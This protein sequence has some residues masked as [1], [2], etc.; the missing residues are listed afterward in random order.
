MH[1]RNRMSCFIIGEG[2]LPIQCAEIL[3]DR[4]HDIYGIVSPDMSLGQWAREK[5]L[6]YL[7]PV[8]NGRLQPVNLHAFLAQ[9]P[10]DYLFSIVNYTFLPEDVLA[11][12]CQKAINYHD[13][14][15]PRYAGICATSWA[16]MQH[17]I[18]HGITWHVATRKIDAGDIIKQCLVD[19]GPDDTAFTLNM[20]CYQAAIEAFAEMVDDLAGGQASFRPQN[21]SERTYYSVYKRP[22]R[23]CV[24]SWDQDTRSIE[25]FVRALEFGP[26]PNR[27]GL[28][29]LA[30]GKDFFIISKLDVLD[31]P[32]PAPPGT[33]V[34]VDRDFLT[35]STQTKQVV[36]RQLTTIEGKPLSIPD[37]ALRL[38]LGKGDRLQDL[39]EALADR[40]TT[41][42]ALICKHEPFWVDRLAA[43]RPLTLPYV[44]APADAELVGASWQRV[45]LP[46]SVLSEVEGFLA[47]HHLDW[48]V[49][50]FMRIAFVAYLA[51]LSGVS[52]FDIGCRAILSQGDG[53]LDLAGLE[54]F[55]AQHV[56]LHV[57][58][59]LDWGFEQIYQAVQV[60]LELI[61]R[62]YTY[63]RDMVARYPRIGKEVG[64]PQWP[65]AIEHV[66]NLDERQPIPGGQ[67]ALLISESDGHP[68][69]CFAY[70]SNCVNEATAASM[71]HQFTLLLHA[72][73]TEGADRP[74]WSL[75]LLTPAERSQIVVEWNDTGI[76]Y[77]YAPQ[78]G[79]HQLFEIQAERTPDAVALVF[80][81]QSLTY[82]ELNRR[83][84]K[85]A[86]YLQGLGVGPETVVG[87]CME[88]CM[89]MVIGLYGTLK[90]GAA[91]MPLDP[92]YPTQRLAFMVEDAQSPLVLTREK[93]VTALPAY[94]RVGPGCPPGARQNPGIVCL[95]ADWEAIAAE[96]ADRLVSKVL[97]DYPAYVIYTS[98]ST[99][100][101]K[102]VIN[103]QAGIRNRLL[104][105]QSAYQLDGSDRV[106][107]KT[108]F[109]FDVSVWEFFWP[110]LTGACLVV[111]QPEG[112]RDNAY[113]IDLIV[114]QNVTTMHFVPSMLRVFI[115]E[116]GIEACR[117]L[118]RVL[119]SGEALPGDLQERFF[120]RL[121]AELHNLYG[122]TE[123]AVDVTYWACHAEGRQRVVPIG[124][125]I[126][127]T[128]IYILDAHGCPVPVG[129]PG[130][131][132]IG[133]AGLARGYLNRP[134]LTAEKFVPDPFSRNPGARLY[135][136]GDLAR[137]LPDGTIEF[138]ERIDYQVKVRGFRIELGEIESTLA[139]HP[140]V[141]KV[142]V[143]A[144][145]DM[146]DHKRLTAYI[147][148]KRDFTP[149]SGALRDFL[150]ERLP[151]YM[152]PSAFVL[153]KALPLTAHGK[154]DRRALPLP[155]Q[156]QPV[157]ESLSPP[158]TSA[159]KTLAKI[160]SQVFGVEVGIHDDFFDE[161][162][163]DS[164][165]GMQI[166]AKANQAGFQ[167]R[168]TTLLKCRTIAA[169][170]AE[171]SVSRSAQ[172]EQNAVVGPVPLTPV[173]RWFFE[174]AIPQPQH[175]NQAF[176]FTLR[177]R[178]SLPCLKM[179]V[180]HVLIHHDALRLRFRREVDG[181]Q[182]I[183]EGP[184]KVE[185]SA[186]VCVVDLS[187]LGAEDQKLA[188]ESAT[189]ELHASLDL[190]EGPL[191]RIALF[192]FGAPRPDQM[193]IVIHHL[194]VDIVSWQILLEDLQ[195]AYHQLCQGKAVELPRKTTSF[196]QW[197][198]R[199]AAYVQSEALQPDVSYWLAQPRDR[200]SQLPRDF[201]GGDN[202]EGSGHGVSAS[203]S[204][205][206]TQALL[207][208]V[209]VACNAR[210]D[211]VLLATLA[212]VLSQWIGSRRMVIDLEGHGREE[213]S[214]DVDLLRTVG[215][216][217]AIF[218]VWLDMGP[219]SSLTDTLQVVQA[220]LRDI[221]KRGMGYGLLRYLS[222]DKAV[223]EQ[224]QDRSPAEVSFNYMGRFDQ[225]FPPSTLLELSQVLFGPL[226]SPSG[227]RRYIF[228]INAGI[229]G[230]QFQL[231]WIYSEN[232][233]RRATVEEL[234]HDFMANLRSLTAQSQSVEVASAV[235]LDRAEQWKDGQPFT[236][237][238]SLENRHSPFPLSDMQQAYWIGRGSTHELGNV[239]PHTYFEFE[240]VGL[241]LDRLNHAL[242][243]VINR[244]EMLRTAVLPDGQQ[245]I[246][247][248]V[249][250]EIEVVDLRGLDVQVAAERLE[251]A[252]ESMSHM[253]K[254][255]DQCPLFE[256]R[257]YLLEN[258]RVRLN[259]SWDS[260]MADAFSLFLFMED[261]SQFYKNPDVLLPPLE[262]SFRDY[263]LA[264][265]ASRKSEAYQRSLSYWQSR[266]STLPP[267]PE[268]PLA[269]SPSGIKYPRF[270]RRL[271]RLEAKRW[272]RIKNRAKQAGLTPA[273]VLCAAHSEI[274]AAWSKS[275]RFTNNV[276][277][278]DRR[279]FHPQ[280]ND[281]VGDFTSGI[282]L[283]TDYS[284]GDTFEAR[285]QGLQNQLWADLEHTRVSSIRVLRELGR[286]Q[287]GA[288][289]AM[290]I[291]FTCVLNLGKRQGGLSLTSW[292]GD[293]VYSS[294]Q[295]PQVW[296]DH[297]IFEDGE[298]LFFTWD[299]VEELFP[300]GL[301]DDMFGAYC[302]LLRRLA[303][304]DKLWRQKRLALVPPD[305]LKRQRDINASGAPI[306]SELLHTLFTAQV[307]KRRPQPAVVDVNRTLTYDE[308]DRRSNQVARRLRAL[309][310]RPNQ[311]VAVVMEKGW[312]Q[313]VAVLGVH[314]A[315]AAYLPVNAEQPQE[316]LHYLLKNGQV[317]V[318]LTQS[319]LD[320]QLE[321]PNAIHRLCVDVQQDWEGLDDSPLEPVQNAKDLAYVIYT[322]GS[323]G[324]PKGVMID[325]QGA[326]NTILDINRRCRIGP[327]DRI[328]ALS[329][330]SFDLSVYD[331]FGALAAGATIVMPHS[332]GWR[333]PAH[334]MPLLLDQG[335]TVWDSV[336]ALMEML[337]DYAET[338]KRPLPST[339]RL[340][341]MSGDWIPVN[342][343]DRIRK[344]RKDV[345]VIS[346]GGA[347]EASIWSILY[348]IGEVD[349]TWKS[350]PYG[351]PMDNQ[352]FYVL[353]ERMEERPVWTPGELY[354]G[355]IGLAL[356]Y[357][358]DKEK[359]AAS[360]VTH[361]WTGERLYRTG[362]L[363]CYL[364]DGNIEFMGRKD[365]QVKVQGYRIELG[366]IEAA[367]L[368]HPRVSA[369]V[370][371]ATG[372]QRSKK[373]L[374]GYVLPAE[375]SSIT[376]DELRHYLESKLPKY[377]IPSVFM[378][379]ETLPLTPN[380]KVDRLALPLPDLSHRPPQA[381]T[382]LKPKATSIVDNVTR[383]AK[384]T[385]LIDDIDPEA[386]FLDLGA[387]SIDIVRL[388]TLLEK[389][390][391]F[392]PEMEELFR[393]QTVAEVSRYY[394]QHLLQSRS[395][396]SVSEADTLLASFRVLLDPEEREAFKHAQHGLRRLHGDDFSAPAEPD[397]TV[398]VKYAERR[399][400]RSFVPCP[401][402]EK[403]FRGFMSC[404]RQIP[405]DGK[406]KYLYGSAG[407]T[408]AVQT[409]LYAKPEGVEGLAPGIYYYHPI[410]DDFALISAAARINQNAHFFQNRTIFEKST[411]SL[412]FICQLS[413]I[414]PLYGRKS[415]DYAM[416]E[417]GLMTQ[418]LE[419]T[420]PAYQIGLCQIGDMDFDAIGKLFDLEES[421]ILL[422]SLVGGLVDWEEGSL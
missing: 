139:Q 189:A 267:A 324:L 220:Q 421:H 138:L 301:L 70:N 187:H 218:P 376:S 280:V 64:R 97:D 208:K 14:I 415:R 307:D 378:M 133:G 243:Q 370:V 228:E 306:S 240:S 185:E 392:R 422:H 380:G 216:F 22:P 108:P 395:P 196:K 21:M 361:P 89:E 182:Q 403:T 225:Y 127:N 298:G 194:L 349:P 111:A 413:A 160:W 259:F 344:L 96:K 34:A 92:T 305:Q 375:A 98:G 101:P 66:S 410:A 416:I 53:Q 25:A 277:L 399:S 221:P 332:S 345:E 371:T 241:D 339:L 107:Q 145:E 288:T 275:P 180:Q 205:E 135:R 398:K 84:N 269:T 122:P 43:L 63:A 113:L 23:G 248:H 318:V 3:L 151:D 350:I 51:R 68:A 352:R 297:Q 308:L 404:L 368:Q 251:A 244:H 222:E 246:L 7:R 219:A 327:Q 417:A 282:L 190:S 206:D 186:P 76:D 239:T 132:Y 188:L 231:E 303:D 232:I 211:E 157:P 71:L 112:H 134:A 402:P 214:E 91:Y 36:L 252:R 238:P 10:F 207:Q 257:A 311:L 266:L 106:M 284:A 276:S 197:S 325:H 365:F 212:Q 209:P 176:L 362:D 32:S 287:G 191:V 294:S 363:G 59:D 94:S 199:L 279:P 136:S 179:A 390:F 385:L 183:N 346:L 11:L 281:I 50:D 411:F 1:T 104:W 146:A 126:A 274:M 56:P 229:V 195:T 254:P 348:P 405:L 382:A 367:L 255:A 61:G 326:V 328:F 272:R 401:I 253:V 48:R 5:Q 224:L 236:I 90:A 30:A 123:A 45:N 105:M 230:E 400:Y 203:L 373:R 12:P 193:V 333:D 263:T 389:E 9:R 141:Q 52:V 384:D 334:W 286:A 74:L 302:H 78:Q 62:H 114:E 379:M 374:V 249:P 320:Q 2:T 300:K 304:E 87:V 150:K 418:L 4:G 167:F 364:P 351:R 152:V 283:E 82:A 273:M 314:K 412:F 41:S 177:C 420:A 315:G 29:K 245:Q 299:A 156:A 347:T 130:E 85:L 8:Y 394:E 293:L 103:T 235:L 54:G 117:S 125:P 310:A 178:L 217:T 67:L 18:V 319:W 386:N 40:L 121:D 227:P 338:Q 116:P 337:V 313:V 131:L 355:G 158:R 330:L 397:D 278:F 271:N 100:T 213:V 161:L 322:S 175:W 153:L 55:F 234:A 366:E 343:P 115:E 99:G 47:T 124:H 73:I 46:T 77:S 258:Q 17:E 165:L 202:T 388:A 331:I 142:V 149:A 360:F 174:Q 16:I 163:G 340:V 268:L 336:P 359:T 292:L 159:E 409:Y 44:F 120:A 181:W 164:I 341:L 13:A 201:P 57:E 309:G 19:V 24:V 86:H 312:E 270:M 383:L 289:T 79:I 155:E 42:N 387:N 69:C 372:E 129:T 128:Q 317:E 170:A 169:L 408:Y 147:V 321:W 354:I 172:A 210:I 396:V 414:A 140:A 81:N 38:G 261:W 20:K 83:A 342:L 356:G 256:V 296:L 204:V 6:P 329:R 28:P 250:Y 184:D 49:D 233:H 168:P 143:L 93:Y 95:D 237:V 223:I 316:R 75:P 58:M 391:G 369:A 295:A 60:E 200:P 291:V 357:W 335:V 242:Q 260:L 173:Q 110:L 358:Q 377:M 265:L 215:W 15:L 39:D 166:V 419:M 323:T 285:A 262:L 37:L 154:V 26:Y 226:H 406:P 118:R 102:G 33:L 137:Y 109:S 381:E 148:A 393:L 171:V 198:E 88:R 264:E 31:A 290:P 247:E 144:R 119:C 27:L 407:P 353:D 80:Q 72:I 35:L 162:G 192:S 65:I